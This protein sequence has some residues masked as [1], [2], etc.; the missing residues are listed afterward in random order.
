MSRASVLAL[1][2]R[3]ATGG[4]S[5]T[6][7][8]ERLTGQDT[9][10]LTAVVTDSYT[11]VYS[12]A[13]RVQTAGG[14]AGQVEVGEAAPRQGSATLQLPVVGSSGIRPRDRVTILTCANDTELVGRIYHVTGEHHGSH[15]S[16]RRLAIDE[17]T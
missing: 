5:D 3:F 13:C 14:P 12:G 11:T 16:A 10:P 7:R 2:R 17:V 9:H 4:F 1:A 6:C 8:V 15:K